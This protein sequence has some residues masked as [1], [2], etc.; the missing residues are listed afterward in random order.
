MVPTGETDLQAGPG[1]LVAFHYRLLDAEGDM[2]DVTVE[3]LRA[4]LGAGRL[5]AGL[6][7]SLHGRRAGERYVVE[8]APALAYGEY[9]ADAVRA[10]PRA[11]FPEDAVLGVG[12]QHEAAA[13]DGTSLPFWVAEVD[14][15][16]V[17]ADFNHP[18]AGM[19]VAFDVLVLEVRRPTLGELGELR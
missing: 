16:T 5:V 4:I 19:D 9:D 17:V 8:L 18:F 13:D 11:A 6:E 10:I 1:L 14:G 12:A 3:P 15:D 2:L 7:Q